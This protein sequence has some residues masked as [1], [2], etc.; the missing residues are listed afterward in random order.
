[1][2]IIQGDNGIVV[3]FIVSKS[4]IESLEGATVTVDIKRGADLLPK[5]AAIV[6]VTSGKCEFTLSNSDLTIAGIY[7][8]QWTAKFEDGRSLSGKKQDFYVS[9]KLIAGNSVPD[10][11]TGGII[12]VRVDGG[13]F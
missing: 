8:Y 3:P 10:P 11:G 7:E 9:E 6:D 12:T 2:S 13:V 1:L 5:S 4:K